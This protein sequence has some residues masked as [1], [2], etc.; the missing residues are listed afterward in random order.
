MLWLSSGLSLSAIIDLPQMLV[1]EN[2]IALKKKNNS[3]F[4]KIIFYQ[5][6]LTCP[7]KRQVNT[8]KAS[9]NKVLEEFLG[10]GF[11]SGLFLRCNDPEGQYGSEQKPSSRS[12]TTKQGKCTCVCDEGIVLDTERLVNG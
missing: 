10:I 3:E 6:Q 11:L 8:M 12:K 2:H 9:L 1:V 4:L 7:L 5:L